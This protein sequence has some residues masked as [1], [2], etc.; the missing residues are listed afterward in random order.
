[1][2]GKITD[3]AD[4]DG[5]WERQ[6]E[7]FQQTRFYGDYFELMEELIWY[8]W[9]TYPGLTSLEILRKIQKDLQEQ[10]MEPGIFENRDKSRLPSSSR[11]PSGRV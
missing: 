10:N 5:G 8:E 6:M 9:S 1:M 3:P 4:A 11:S 2:I 7:E